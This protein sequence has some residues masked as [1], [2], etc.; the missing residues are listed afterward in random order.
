MCQ[1]WTNKLTERQ[2]GRWTN[3]LTDKHENQQTGLNLQDTAFVRQKKSIL[4]TNKNEL[5]KKK[6]FSQKEF[7]IVLYD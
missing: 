1:G 5:R 4:F 7:F 6:N 2:T 3:K